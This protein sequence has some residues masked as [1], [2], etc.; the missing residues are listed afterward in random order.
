[1]T[2]L[3]WTRAKT[4]HLHPKHAS[5]LMADVDHV[6][7]SL[8]SP[9]EGVK[10]LGFASTLSPQEAAELLK[11][12][13]GGDAGSSLASRLALVGIAVGTLSPNRSVPRGVRGIWRSTLPIILVGHIPHRTSRAR[14]ISEQVGHLIYGGRR[15][16]S[17][18]SSASVF[19]GYFEA[20]LA[21]I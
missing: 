16:A 7:R 4:R 5:R 8:D 6:W 11:E 2:T 9:A 18:L 20:G 12:R 21:G 1:M 3:I 15:D 17:G 10:I 14:E 13:M 19:A